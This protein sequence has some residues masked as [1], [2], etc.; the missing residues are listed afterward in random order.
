MHDNAHHDIGVYGSSA[1][2]LVEVNI[3]GV[4]TKYNGISAGNG[5]SLELEKGSIK[6]VLADGSDLIWIR[7]R[8]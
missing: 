8:Y 1:L 5:A 3:S 6:N 2:R 7:C 4:N